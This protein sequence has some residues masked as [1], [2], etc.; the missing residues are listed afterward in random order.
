M[1]IIAFG[2]FCF[3]FG[4]FPLAVDL[5]TIQRLY[6]L[7]SKPDMELTV[8]EPVSNPSPDHKVSIQST[9]SSP[10]S[11]S[12]SSPKRSR[13]SKGGVLKK[14]FNSSQKL[15]EVEN[16]VHWEGLQIPERLSWLTKPVS[17]LNERESACF[18]VF[19]AMSD[20]MKD[21]ILKPSDVFF[22]LDSDGNG[23]IDCNEL[24]TGVQFMCLESG[25][26]SEDVEEFF[27]LLASPS[28]GAIPFWDLQ[29]ALLITIKQKA[30][31][32]ADANF[33]LKSY[34]EMNSVERKAN[35]FLTDI[36]KL[37]EMKRWTP[38]E[39]F[40]TFCSSD[41]PAVDSALLVEK[42][43]LLLRY[44]VGRCEGI[45]IDTPFELIDP[46][47][48][49]VIE[50]SEF[51]TLVRQ[52]VKA[53]SLQGDDAQGRQRRQLQ[54]A[55]SALAESQ[56]QKVFMQAPS[57]PPD[58]GQRRTRPS[59]VP[60]KPVVDVFG[61]R[62]F[63]ECLLL[64]A[65]EVLGF[66]GSS[67]QA[68]QPAYIKAIWLLLFLRWQFGEKQIQEQAMQE[69]E[70]AYL[71]GVRRQQIKKG[72]KLFSFDLTRCHYL[73][74]LKQLFKVPE[75]FED[76]TQHADSATSELDADSSSAC[77]KCGQRPHM[78]WGNMLCP[79]CSLA[80]RVLAACLEEE[81]APCKS[82][83]HA[84]KTGSRAAEQDGRYNST[85]KH[86]ETNRPDFISMVLQRPDPSSSKT[87]LTRRGV[88]IAM[89]LT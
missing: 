50:K 31:L 43:K 1:S 59:Q 64:L 12:N 18:F 76:V 38:D 7:C 17:S 6:H 32:D 60:P 71:E 33:F 37:M 52:F 34:W 16:L 36:A 85:D 74:P 2:R 89:L 24:Q 30:K 9:P 75:L 53:R 68:E 35:I 40:Q 77:L 15:T 4:L 81:Q 62:N 46:L 61:L 88:P 20:W 80:D 25:P 72:E 42:A 69:Q 47:G 19:W 54:A 82:S 10:S 39:L 48:A 57:S 26:A 27:P 22:F 23:E 56:Q 5:Q 58:P 67:T 51:L 41:T 13:S 28:T 65:F 73:Q 11:P 14:T 70:Q 8:P 44:N 78:G 87:T 84:E 83:N 29:Q 79:F 3:D 49:G 21:R 63:I 66:R 45:E 55:T 86:Q